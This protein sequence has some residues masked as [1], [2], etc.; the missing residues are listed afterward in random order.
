MKKVFLFMLFVMLVLSLCSCSSFVHEFEGADAYSESFFASFSYH[1]HRTLKTKIAED[2]TEVV[3][4]EPTAIVPQNF[5]IQDIV[6]YYNRYEELLPLGESVQTM[7]SVRYSAEN[8]EKELGLISQTKAEYDTAHFEYP[9]YVSVLSWENCS[10]YVLVDEENLTLHYVYLQS[11]DKEG[12]H[13][14]TPYLPKG[15][16]GYGAV[17]GVSVCVYE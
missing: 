2:G 5:E 11:V 1:D 4:V 17:E 7:L 10:E 9:A 16:S 3:L 14:D 6:K 13:I 15:Y 8:F 12:L